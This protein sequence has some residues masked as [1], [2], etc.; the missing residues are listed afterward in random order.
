MT[1]TSDQTRAALVS[2]LTEVARCATT[3]GMP[4]ADYVDCL[5]T[6][7]L[8]NLVFMPDQRGAA[9][10]FAK[11]LLDFVD[12][13]AFDDMIALSDGLKDGS[14]GHIGKQRAKR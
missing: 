8:G 12:S 1:T 14:I 4:R 6:H 7:L 10:E 13:P 9:Y 3:I 11:G 2:A 5:L